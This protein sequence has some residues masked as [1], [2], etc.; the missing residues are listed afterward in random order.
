MVAGGLS[1]DAPVSEAMT[2][3]A[4]TVA[5]DRLGSEVWLDMLDRG[6]RHFP[7]LSATGEVLGV[8][9]DADLVAAETRTSFHLR[10]AIARATTT[11]ELAAAARD[12]RPTIVALHRA[13]TA[14]LHLAG[15]HS[16]VV[17][18]LIRRLIELAVADVGEPPTPFAWL[19]LGSLA[20]RE[21]LPGSDVDS[22][23][24]WRGEDDGSRDPRLRAGGRAAASTRASSP[25]AC[26]STRRAPRPPTRCSSARWRPGAERRRAGSRTRRRS[27]R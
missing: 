11:D 25:A 17:D 14:P 24:A 21:A 12:L 16:V 23:V 2:A 6:V 19:A 27:R 3:P 13:R 5:A 7:V 15:I 8:V 10:A 20:R 22:A 9:E 1:F 26:G 4:Y 18:A